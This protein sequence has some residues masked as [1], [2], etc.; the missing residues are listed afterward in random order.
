MEWRCLKSRVI[1]S[2]C[3]VSNI[4]CTKDDISYTKDD[5]PRFSLEFA[6]KFQK[7]V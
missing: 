6:L 2:L 3:C 4:S 5:A 1:K 7:I